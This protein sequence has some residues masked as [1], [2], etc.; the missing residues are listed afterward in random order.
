MLVP[1]H[2]LKPYCDPKFLPPPFTG[3]GFAVQSSREG[4][5]S[6]GQLSCMSSDKALY[7][8]CLFA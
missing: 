6:Q 5:C 4:L 7:L 2:P 1:E 3:A 8:S